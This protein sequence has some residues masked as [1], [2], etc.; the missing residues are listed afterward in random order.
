MNIQSNQVLKVTVDGEF[1][2]HPDAD[3]LIETGDY[4]NSPAMR[5]IL[6]ALRKQHTWVELTDEDKE[7][8]MKVCGFSIPA[9]V[10]RA[11]EDKLKEKFL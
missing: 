1:E 6:R 3:Q 5:H 10:F 2:W 7:D 8:V 9:K 4:S 11:I